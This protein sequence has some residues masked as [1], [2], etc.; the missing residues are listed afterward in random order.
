MGMSR[1]NQSLI[2]NIGNNRK[3]LVN[4]YHKNHKYAVK[5]NFPIKN[6]YKLEQEILGAIKQ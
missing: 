3:S 5:H 2:A 4:D 1:L 6:V